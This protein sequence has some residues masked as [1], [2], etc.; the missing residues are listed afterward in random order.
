MIYTD[1]N[2]VAKSE[3]DLANE[4]IAQFKR[5]HPRTKVFDTWEERPESLVKESKRFLNSIDTIVGDRPFLYTTKELLER[6]IYYNIGQYSFKAPK[7]QAL[8]KDQN[9]YDW[10]SYAKKLQKEQGGDRRG[11]NKIG[12]QEIQT[13]KT[14]E[15]QPIEIKEETLQSTNFNLF[16]YYDLKLWLDAHKNE[17]T[18]ISIEKAYSY[19]ND[20]IE[21]GTGRGAEIIMKALMRLFLGIWTV[22]QFNAA[23]ER[24]HESESYLFKLYDE[25]IE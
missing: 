16:G 13:D 10:V 6:A 12:T 11:I 19:W 25:E 20:F 8:Y 4:V 23:I 2:E 14:E 24:Y 21:W 3:V 9:F 15:K 7:A 22:E 18:T 5:T 17:L 1:A